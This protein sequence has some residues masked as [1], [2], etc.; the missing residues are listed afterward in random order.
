M[1]PRLRARLLP[2]P[3]SCQSCKSCLGSLRPSPGLSLVESPPAH[4]ESRLLN[5]LFHKD[6][7]DIIPAGWTTRM[8]AA[9]HDSSGSPLSAIMEPDSPGLSEAGYSKTK[10]PG[11]LGEA[12]LPGPPPGPRDPKEEIPRLVGVNSAP[13]FPPTMHPFLLSALCALC[14][15]ISPHPV[16]PEN[17]VKI[18]TAL[19]SSRSP[20]NTTKS[21]I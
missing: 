7:F 16:H 5:S 2:S 18:P 12:A 11:A 15:E 17:P 1:P 6:T 20:K 21:R 13:P 4:S 14:G 9:S 3:G 8:R 10:Q 19:F